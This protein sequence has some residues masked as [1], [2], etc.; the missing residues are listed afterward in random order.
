MTKNKKL[1]IA[2]CVLLGVLLVAGV[3]AV[4]TTNYGS[5]N[6]PLITLSYI[7]QTVRPALK[8][9]ID[10]AAAS[11]K[12][13]LSARFDSQITNFSSAMD[14][15]IAA[16]G[17]ASSGSGETFAVVTLTNRQVIRCQPGTEILVRTGN[18]TAYGG[19]SPRLVDSTSGSELSA[20]GAALKNNHMY[21]VPASG[22][23]LRAASSS[24]T[25]LVR[26]EYT[27]H[28]DL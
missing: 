18:A 28:S 17:G 14:A 22:N 1:L 5:A 16:S 27:V 15:K 19:S 9:D 6:D 20:A 4:A 24:V 25:L 26:G 13:D 8:S 11:A 10:T 12:A 2:L 23:G 7:N 3:T 21:I